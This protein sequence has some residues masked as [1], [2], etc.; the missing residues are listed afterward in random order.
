MRTADQHARGTNFGD[1]D[2]GEVVL[3]VEQRQVQLSETADPQGDVTRPL[4]FVERA[5]GGIDRTF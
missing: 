4:C 3:V 2:I 5:T 1:G